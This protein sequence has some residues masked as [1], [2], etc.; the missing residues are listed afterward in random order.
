MSFIY[1]QHDDYS[2]PFDSSRCAANVA[3]GGRS[4]SFHQC[5]R[6]KKLKPDQDGNLWCWQ[7]HPDYIKEK[8]EKEEAKWEQEKESQNAK[9][10]RQRAMRNACEGVPTE[11]LETIKVKYLLN[12]R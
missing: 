2:S 7:H 5:E 4:V 6:N 1:K 11:M 10:R 8:R 12:L 9:W 3:W